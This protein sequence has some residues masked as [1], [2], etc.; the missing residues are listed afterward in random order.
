MSSLVNQEGSFARI[1]PVAVLT[2]IC[3]TVAQFVF[4]GI[5]ISARSLA[6]VV[7]LV[8]VLALAAHSRSRAFPVVPA[9]GF[10]TPSWSS[11]V[12]ASGTRDVPAGLSVVHVRP[13]IHRVPPSCDFCNLGKHFSVRRIGTVTVLAILA[14]SVTPVLWQI[15]LDGVRVGEASHPGPAHPTPEGAPITLNVSEVLTQVSR[16]DPSLPAALSGAPVPG[17]SSP[18][19]PH[20]YAAPPP[21]LHSRPSRFCTPL[22]LATHLAIF[23]ALRHPVAVV[24]ALLFALLRLFLKIPP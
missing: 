15:G 23:R 21:P 17:P 9:P 7:A 1:A 2:P 12:P 16:S 5:S 11:V 4:W 22:F 14:C 19:A 8:S 20:P 13:L 3:Q 18:Q 10:R 6:C 24:V